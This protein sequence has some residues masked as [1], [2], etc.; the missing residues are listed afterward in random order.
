MAAL[1]DWAVCAT[2]ARRRAWILDV[3]RRADPDAWRDGVR[4]PA[5]WTDRTAL[6]E[7]AQT[8][9]VAGQPAPFLVALGERLH[10]L[11]GDGTGFLAR[12]HQEHPD[13]FWAAFTLAQALQD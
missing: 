12:V 9:P 3:A 8:A 4:D 10:D 7:L 6:A 5:A 13:D 2:D 11:G 1:D